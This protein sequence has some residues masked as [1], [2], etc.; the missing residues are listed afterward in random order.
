MRS[1]DPSLI[2]A[3]GWSAYTSSAV[4]AIGILFLILLYVGFFTNVESLLIFGSIGDALVVVQYL[5]ALPIAVALYRALSPRSPRLSLIAIVLAF[6]GVG[7]VVVFQLL[8]ITGVMSFSEELVYVSTSFLV[9]A[10]WIVITSLVGRRTM[11][12]Q[13]GVPTIILGALYF[14]YPL[15]VYRIGQHLLAAA[16]TKAPSSEVSP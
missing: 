2:R 10:M 11:A 1:D 14:G 15:W 4:S 9:V 13:I 7:G 8:V 12:L 16:R 6:A 3:A 5:L